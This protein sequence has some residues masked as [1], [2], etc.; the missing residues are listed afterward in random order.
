MSHVP[1]YKL[2]TPK[3]NINTSISPRNNQVTP[4]NPLF[5]PGNLSPLMYHTMI[6]MSVQQRHP[7]LRRNSYRL[8]IAIR[9][10]GFRVEDCFA[11]CA[12]CQVDQ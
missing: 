7:S 2:E 5:S 9:A 3:C 8:R 1:I 12:G 4:Q 10:R 11:A 6:T